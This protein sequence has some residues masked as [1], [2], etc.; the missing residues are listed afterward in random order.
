MYNGHRTEI[1]TIKYYPGGITKKQAEA[2]RK[3]WF[4]FFDIVS[5]F[6]MALIII[7]F[8]FTFAF[9]IA[10]VEGRS[11][12]PTLYDGDWLVVSGRQSFERGDIVI[13]T[14]PNDRN[15]PLVKRVI[16][17]GGDNID[18]NFTTGEVFINGE[19]IDEPYIKEPTKR[20]FDVQFPYPV[21]EGYV[22]VMGD[23]RNDSLDSR[24][25]EIGCIDERYIL[26]KAVFR[27]LPFDNVKYFGF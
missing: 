22:F 27:V 5:S 19:K 25:S 21:P 9:R 6:F 3:S 10:N 20:S 8:C 1:N 7:L 18:I 16:A 24:S 17:V 15:E 11:M 12:V 14:Q 4:K 13:V 23:N 2:K 26:G